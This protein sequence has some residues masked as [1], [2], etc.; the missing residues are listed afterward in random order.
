MLSDVYDC[1]HEQNKQVARIVINAPEQNRERTKDL[2]TRFREL[3]EG[4]LL[5]FWKILLPEMVRNTSL[6]QL[7]LRSLILLDS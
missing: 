3:N 6:C 2:M 5:L 4:P 7:P 1:V